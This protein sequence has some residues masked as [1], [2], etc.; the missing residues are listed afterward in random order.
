MRPRTCLRSS[1][2]NARTHTMDV[3][4]HP[5]NPQRQ[6]SDHISWNF[7]LKNSIGSFPRSPRKNPV[8]FNGQDDS[9]II[10]H[11]QTNSNN[12]N[13]KKVQ[14]ASAGSKKT[15]SKRKREFHAVT[16]AH[17]ER[18]LCMQVRKR[19][20]GRRRGKPLFACEKRKAS[21]IITS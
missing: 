11:S 15:N 3:P 7:L 19:A 16:P 14:A 13:I 5:N 4:I 8:K 10:I 18:M 12:C 17:V 1:S 20:R 9:T 21:K 2:N 6:T